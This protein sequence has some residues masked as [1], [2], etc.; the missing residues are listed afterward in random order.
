MPLGLALAAT[1]LSVVAAT[2]APVSWRAIANRTS[3]FHLYFRRDSGHSSDALYW[4]PVVMS[5]LTSW[6][7]FGLSSG[8][9]SLW[10]GCE[11]A[12]A[13]PPAIAQVTP[14]GTLSTRV[15]QSGNNFTIDL[16]DRSGNNL[17]HSFGQFS[18]PTG[19][20]AIFN[21]APD[22]QNIFSRV[23]GGTVSNIDG[24]IRANGAANLFLLNPSGILFG[25]NASLS[26]G[27]SFVG[28]TAS[29][30]KFADS[31]EF[32]ATNATEPPLLTM[33]VPIGLQM[34]QSPG[35]ITV[36]GTGHN[37]RP[38]GFVPTLLTA[39]P[40][41]L[42]V[43]PGNTLALVGN[44]ITLVGG[45]LS[46]PSGQVE[47]GSVAGG[48]IDMLR[49]PQGWRFN[50]SNATELGNISLSQAAL[51]NASGNPGG[52]IHLRGRDI[53][54]QDSAVL[55]I[56]NLGTQDAGQISIQAEGLLDMRGAL[57]NRSPS[58]IISETMNTGAGADI[59]ISANQIWLSEGAI[60]YSG[61]FLAGGRGGDI[62]VQATDS[63]TATGVSPLSTQ[64]SGF[65][66]AAGI[67]GGQG[68]NLTLATRQL[69]VRD[70]AAL[71]TPV[72]GGLKGGNLNVT[73]DQIDV[74]GESSNGSASIIASTTLFGGD[75]GQMQINVRQLL[76]Q[77]GGVIATTTLGTGNAGN[78]VINA[79]ES[80][81]V[82]GQGRFV[83]SSRI[84]ASGEILNPSLQQ[85]VGF[86]SKPTGN[87]GDIKINTPHLEVSDGAG[88]LAGHVGTGATGTLEINAGEIRLEQG[89]IGVST[90]SGQGGDINLTAGRSLLLRRGSEISAM[91]GGTGNGGNITIHAPIIIGLENSD[92]IAN[93]IQGMGGNIQ[94]TTQGIFGLKYR[95]RL[96]P[97]NDITA[98]SDFGVNGTVD[99]VNPGIDP[100]FGLVTLPVELVDPS[101][102]LALGCGSQRGSSFV[103]SGRGGIAQNP[104]SQFHPHRPWADVR[105]LVMDRQ[106]VTQSPAVTQLD[107]PL[108][109]A[110]G[111]RRNP[112]GKVELFAA[113]QLATGQTALTATCAGGR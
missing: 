54:L 92:I 113:P 108:V 15:T 28:T 39:T 65:T 18:V 103:I 73:A 46:A 95:D 4:L 112:D 11:L 26:I 45:I 111:W 71:G 37:L 109:E 82:A 97:E 35:A 105:N 63:I 72:F 98:S 14:D 38:N 49:S 96:T 76:L 10:V 29:R 83:D 19:G 7:W 20:A 27:G 25:P 47:I 34:G 9:T 78:L 58:T 31:T 75:A 2:I 8:L 106:P 88:I 91:A 85:A 13:L 81:V 66:A 53:K 59:S 90:N 52:S 68:G 99:I 24:V 41:G 44:T 79:T 33:S 84:S 101:R 12:I 43:S 30:I 17:F 94:V 21:N 22:V 1:D 40:A 74:I 32:S 61:N 50:Y 89:N 36:Q 102:N 93:A 107:R 100:N 86:S 16:G 70:G 110:T 62:S 51:I 3:P 55:L 23:T 67:G 64:I 6:A 60:I 69:S 5:R 104:I 57:P 87:A 77:A 48:Q 80:I 42:S 56:Q